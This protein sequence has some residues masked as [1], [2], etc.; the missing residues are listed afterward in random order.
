MR[1][2]VRARKAILLVAALFVS[3][4]VVVMVLTVVRAQFRE[5]A[6][7]DCVNS[8]VPPTS[9]GDVTGVSMDG[10]LSRGHV[11]LGIDFAGRV[12]SRWRP[13]H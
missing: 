8:P 7:E 2:F 1:W 11:C 5:A 10:W 6:M 12:V 4:A 3:A 13:S 9:R